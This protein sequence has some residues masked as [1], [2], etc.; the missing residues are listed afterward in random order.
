MQIALGEINNAKILCRVI[1][2]QRTYSRTYRGA[3][4]VRYGTKHTMLSVVLLCFGACYS[5]IV[6]AE[7]RNIYASLLCD[8]FNTSESRN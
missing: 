6:G 4:K 1:F 3:Q 7:D 2:W 8:D 5:C